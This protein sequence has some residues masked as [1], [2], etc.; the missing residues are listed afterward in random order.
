MFAIAEGGSVADEYAENK[1]M[2]DSFL[3]GHVN[4]KDMA[5]GLGEMMCWRG[6]SNVVH[7]KSSFFG[8]CAG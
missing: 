1:A 3:V 7:N 6:I 2:L 5:T 8:R 4:D